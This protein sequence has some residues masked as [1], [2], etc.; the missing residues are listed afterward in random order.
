MIPPV[1]SVRLLKD[2][3]VGGKLADERRT[4]VKEEMEITIQ[5]VQ[6]DTDRLILVQSM[7]ANGRGRDIRVCL[8]DCGFAAEFWWNPLSFFPC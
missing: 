7:V 8:M 1:R 2:F 4:A 5:T 3:K 6:K